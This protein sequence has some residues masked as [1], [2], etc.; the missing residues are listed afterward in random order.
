VLKAGDHYEVRNAQD[1]YG[2]PVASGTYGG[3]SVTIPLSAVAAP[4]PLA[5]VGQST[6][7][8][9]GTEFNAFIV[10]RRDTP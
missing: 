9:T 8:Q 6:L 10:M 5:G 2:S 4:A 3:G 7:S 1:F